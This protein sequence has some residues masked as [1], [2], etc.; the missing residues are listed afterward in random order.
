MNFEINAEFMP[1]NPSKYH[2]PIIGNLGIV[3]NAGRLPFS[4][5][6]HNFPEA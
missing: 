6:T 1:I 4:V 3:S 2:K 5:H